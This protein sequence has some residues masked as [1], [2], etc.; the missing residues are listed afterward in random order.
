MDIVA[1]GKRVESFL[2]WGWLEEQSPEERQTKLAEVMQLLVDGVLRPAE[3]S[4]SM[5]TLALSD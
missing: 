3:G 1:L 4:L 2:V 5:C